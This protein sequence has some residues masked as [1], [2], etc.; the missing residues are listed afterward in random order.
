MTKSEWKQAAE[1][2]RK[3]CEKCHH[4]VPVQHRC[5]RCEKEER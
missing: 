5:H 3:P 2:G 1:T 4:G